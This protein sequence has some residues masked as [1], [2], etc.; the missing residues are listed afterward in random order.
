MSAVTSA[1]RPLVP[2]QLTFNALS[3]IRTVTTHTIVVQTGAR[4]IG[5]VASHR[6]EAASTTVTRG[7]RPATM[8]APQNV[9]ATRNVSACARAIEPSAMAS[10]RRRCTTV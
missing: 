1:N 5:V 6:A 3:A 7:A 9:T 10:V 8:S 2:T 4:A